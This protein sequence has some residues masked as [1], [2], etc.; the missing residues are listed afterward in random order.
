MQLNKILEAFT[1]CKKPLK[2]K[3][4]G[5]KSY[6]Y[7]AYE[8][9][10]H[11]L[12]EFVGLA[13]VSIDYGPMQY[14]QI[15]SGQEMFYTSCTVTIYDDS[16]KSLSRTGYGGR[17]VY[18]NDAGKEVNLQ[19]L[20]ENVQK[21][22][23]KNACKAFGLLIPPRNVETQNNISDKNP[24]PQ[25]SKDRLR[26]SFITEGPFFIYGERKGKSI[27]KVKT[28]LIDGERMKTDVSEIVFYPN[29]T[30]DYTD[31]MNQYI[32][33]SQSAPQKLRLEVTES[34]ARDGIQQYIF[35]RFL[36]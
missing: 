3:E 14:I 33:K 27:Y 20:P 6:P 35:C 19:N 17:E 26:L 29:R 36:K 13:N 10:I 22:A 23:F 2:H 9:Y 11:A 7:Y 32:S 21:L 8:H 28:H 30:K 24:I 25:N 18:F 4:Y 15:T 12:D 16:N 1:T 31:F 34:G 5:N